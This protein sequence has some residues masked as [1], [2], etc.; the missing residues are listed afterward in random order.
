M[1]NATP[2][3]VRH[4][5]AMSVRRRISVCVVPALVLAMLPTVAMADGEAEAVKD[6]QFPAAVRKLVLVRLEADQG[7]EIHGGADA[8]SSC[9]SGSPSSACA[10]RRWLDL[11]GLGHDAVANDTERANELQRA[12]NNRTDGT[13]IGEAEPRP[14]R[15]RTRASQAGLPDSSPQFVVC[16]LLGVPALDFDGDDYLRLAVSPSLTP[17]KGGM[18]FVVALSLENGLGSESKTAGFSAWVSSGNPGMFADSHFSLTTHFAV[19]DDGDYNL[20]EDAHRFTVRAVPVMHDPM[21]PTIRDRAT[22][23]SGAVQPGTP[24]VVT[25]ELTGRQLLA[26]LDGDGSRWKADATDGS[27][28]RGAINA[29]EDLPDAAM[30]LG[31][32]P[33]SVDHHYFTGQG[34]DGRLYAVLAF[35]GKL[36]RRVLQEVEQ[37]VACRFKFPS[38][39]EGSHAEDEL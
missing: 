23:H 37:Y 34:G 10:V 27:R 19:K 29:S 33:S 26:R 14:P 25:F 22:L 21:L 11:S 16:P 4:K 5:S 6:K 8:A 30:L 31:S 20:A 7:V 3:V 18:T 2:E 36:K 17:G 12:A 32:G 15:A 1:A 28:Y 38:C 35:Q 24:H 39:F 13:L 9:G